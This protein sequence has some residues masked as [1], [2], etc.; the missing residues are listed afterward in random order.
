MMTAMTKKN[1]TRTMLFATALTAL[2]FTFSAS[3]DAQGFDAPRR[4]EP[5]HST[6]PSATNHYPNRLNTMQPQH[7]ASNHVSKPA[8]MPTVCNDRHHNSQP[9]VVLIGQ[10][11]KKP[12]LLEKIVNVFR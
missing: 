5:N 11:P 2:L 7:H 3:A 12:T 4:P 10:A 8:P 1:M 9:Q 6:V